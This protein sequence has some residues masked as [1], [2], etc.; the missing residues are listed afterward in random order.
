MGGAEDDRDVAFLA[1][2]EHKRRAEVAASEWLRPI[3]SFRDDTLGVFSAVR[4]G[5]RDREA[6][7]AVVASEL[8]EQRASIKI[9]HSPG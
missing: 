1:A 8:L 2:S 5:E 4:S 3:P 7:L 9:A 6:L